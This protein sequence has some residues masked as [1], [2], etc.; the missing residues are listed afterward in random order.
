MSV[1][2][3]RGE[4]AERFTVEQVR[5]A[6]AVLYSPEELAECAL[7][8]ILAEGTE[9]ASPSDRARA[10]RDSLLGAMEALQPRGHIAP[11]ASAYRAQECIRLRY[12]SGLTVS[13]I[14]DELSL[15]WRQVYRDLRLGEQGI[16]E[17][18]LARQHA[19]DA[20]TSDDDALL[21]E[22]GALE[23]SLRV[24]DLAKIAARAVETVEAM[25][26][27]QQIS[28]EYRGPSAGVD[29]RAMPGIL[30]GLLVQLLSASLQ[31]ADRQELAL[32]LVAD[33]RNAVLSLPVALDEPSHGGLLDSALSLATTQ[34]VPGMAWEVAEGPSARN[35]RLILSR[36]RRRR[37]LVVEDNPAAVALYERYLAD[38]DWETIVAPHP[39]TAVDIATA[40]QVECVIL[41]IM[42]PDADGWS[43]LQA[44]ML[45]RATRKIPV[46]VC[47]VVTDRA[48]GLALGAT[49]YITKPVTRLALLEAL[50]RAAGRGR[51]A[52]T[53]PDKCG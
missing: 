37:V 26:A 23:G 18:L 33:A 6:L 45:G 25:A 14:A 19:G 43:V 21:R 35:L 1:A 47:S 30:Q 28:V 5:E 3:A 48:L 10:L 8:R 49:E 9:A 24:V 40:S 53:G 50:S 16:L 13:E 31:S 34:T 36:F 32:D 12:C 29:V 2:D 51:P 4:R 17:Q 22:V 11:R 38:S 42:M 7:V 41:D 39:R 44:L 27:R 20:S 15:G 46:V 52:S